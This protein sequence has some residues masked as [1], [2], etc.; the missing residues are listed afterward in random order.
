VEVWLAITETGLHSDVKRGEN[1]GHD[2]HH[3]AVVRS[4]RKIG[5]AKGGEEISFAGDVNVALQSDW[6][7]ENLKAVVF[8]QGKKGLQIVGAAEAPV[9]R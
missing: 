7:R 3:A 6:K 9:A 4:I 5:E 1:S 2:L 8:V